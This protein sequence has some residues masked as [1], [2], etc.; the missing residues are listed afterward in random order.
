MQ[1]NGHLRTKLPRQ[2]KAKDNQ[3]RP[4]RDVVGEIWFDAG[5]RGGADGPHESLSF[6]NQSRIL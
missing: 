2:R 6:P 3:P 5:K 4:V 1:C